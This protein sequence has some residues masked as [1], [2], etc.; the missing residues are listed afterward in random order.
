MSRIA[1][2]E[3]EE[4]REDRLD[5]ETARKVLAEKGP[6]LKWTDLKKE[7]DRA[8]RDLSHQRDNRGD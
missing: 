7:L 6:N 2:G 5:L 4:A 8:E 1:G 3:A